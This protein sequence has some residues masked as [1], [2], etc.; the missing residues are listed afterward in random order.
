MNGHLVTV[1]VRVECGTNERVNLD[2]LTF[3]KYRL[4][5]LDSQTVKRRSTVKKNRMLADHV[6]ENVPND[7]L[8]AFDHFACLLD[9]GSVLVFFKLV[10]DERLEKLESHLLGKSTLVQLELRTDYDNRT[11]RIVNAFSEKVL[12][13]TSLLTLERA[14]QRL[15]RAIIRT[16]QHASATPVVKQCVDSFLKHSLFVA[17]D[18]FRSTEL[19]ELLQ[20]IVAVDHA[21]IK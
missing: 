11:S 15:E 20:T 3:N 10:V 16:A 12:A 2:R 8:L 4:K 6:L 14:G 9:R 7:R 21:S 19:D 18:H 1:E 5:S 13:E 17:Y